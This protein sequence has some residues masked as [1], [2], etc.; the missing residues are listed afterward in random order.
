MTRE[1]D[2]PLSEPG[3][4][5]YYEDEWITLYLGDCRDIPAWLT[6]DLLVTDPRVVVANDAVV[7]VAVKIALTPAPSV[8]QARDTAL[9]QWG[10]RIG[11]VFGDLMLPPIKGCKLVGVYAK[12]VTAGVRGAI[13]GLRRDAEAIY[14]IGPWASGIG[15]RSSVFATRVG[16][17][18]GLSARA[19]HPHAKPLDVME[20]LI[21]LAPGVVADP[22]AWSGS[23]LV[24]A[25]AMGR[26]AIGVE[27][28][29]RYCELAARRLAQDVL[30]F[31]AL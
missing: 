7:L 28:D 25:K 11:I 23:T 18:S 9:A 29:E 3:M 14:L 20:A 30:A 24:A 27:I 5:P 15:G 10:D 22:F 16:N 19:G 17:Q 26:R 13:G 4:A 6:A 21:G 31:D 8:R 12:S 1:V 2:P